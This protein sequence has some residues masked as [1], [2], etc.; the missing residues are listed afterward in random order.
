MSLGRL[1]QTQQKK[2][3]GFLWENIVANS[4]LSQK[5]HKFMNDLVFR[6]RMCSYVCIAMT[7]TEN[8]AQKYYI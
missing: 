8:N 2:L 4:K 5:K 3:D 7:H 1:S 6:G